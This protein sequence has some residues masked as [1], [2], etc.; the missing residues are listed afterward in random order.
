MYP[1]NG[2]PVKSISRTC[3]CDN[4]SAYLSGP[5]LTIRFSWITPQ[6]ILPFEVK[7]KPPNILRS[8]IPLRRIMSFRIRFASCSSNGIVVLW[9]VATQTDFRPRLDRILTEFQRR[10]VANKRIELL[11]GD[12]YG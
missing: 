4:A 7:H 3:D 5:I 10:E 2:R 6:H 9:P 8:A 12:N 1:F 11:D